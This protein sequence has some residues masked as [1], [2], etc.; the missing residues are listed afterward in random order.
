MELF[1]AI[2]APWA[3]QMQQQQQHMTMSSTVLLG[4]CLIALVNT[5]TAGE[6]PAGMAIQHPPRDQKGI[7]ACGWQHGQAGC[8]QYQLILCH[9]FSVPSAWVDKPIQVVMPGCPNCQHVTL[10]EST[11]WHECFLSSCPACSVSL[12][13]VVHPCPPHA[14]ACSKLPD[15]TSVLDRHSL[16]CILQGCDQR[17][18]VRWAVQARQGR[19]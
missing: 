1:D 7:T 17:Q 6:G 12:M 9:C 4:L 19:P 18:C 8:S 5:S 2:T 15:I 3:T 10:N 16:A 13:C 14:D 11:S